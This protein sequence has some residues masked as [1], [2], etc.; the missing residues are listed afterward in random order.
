MQLIQALI[1]NFVLAGGRAAQQAGRLPVFELPESAPVSPSK[2]PEWGHFSST[3]ALQIARPAGVPPLETAK[4][5]QVHL[6]EVDFV[7]TTSVTPP[8]FLNITLSGSWLARQVNAILE[9]GLR[10][11]DLDRGQGCKAQMEFVSANPTGPLSVGRARGAVIGDTMANLLKASGYEVEREYY[12]NNAGTQMRI[13]GESLRLRYLEALG[14]EIELPEEYYQ[15]EYLAELARK[16]AAERGDALAEAGWETFKE[17]AEAAMFESIHSTL[18]NL[19]IHMD[20]YFNE[21]SLYEDGSV[22]E[23]LE[24]LRQGGYIYE[25]DGAQW[26]AATRLGGPED[27]VVVKSTGEPTY[28]LPDIAYHVNKL[29]RGFDLVIDVLGADHKDAFP[30]V[31]RGVEAMGYDGS[32]IRMLMNQFVT[33]KGERMSTRAGRFTTLDELVEEVGADVVR[34]FMLM[35]SSESHLEFDLE[36]AKE[37]SEKNPVYYVQYAHTRISSILRKAGELNFEMGE[38]DVSLLV[39]PSEQAL[40][41]QLLDLPQVIQRAVED[42]APH[43]LTTYGRDLATTFHGF[44]RDCLVLDPQNLELSRARLKLATAAKI[45]LARALGLLGVSAPEVM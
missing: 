33:I 17:I 43:H 27:R 42:M 40:I 22:W 37:Q 20:V 44:Y 5:V 23:T 36:L 13:L 41:L 21:N 24:A 18:A 14:T 2:K 29:E 8:G 28:R 4:I 16:V 3:L 9:G 25:K 7:E 1:S 26:F 30:D 32:K 45:G 6:P 39:H 38:G 19:G 15:G 11:A 10:Y 31:V 12:F 35:R 34:F